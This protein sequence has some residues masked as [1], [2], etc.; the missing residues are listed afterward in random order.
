MRHFRRP[1]RST[2]ELTSFTVN[3][4]INTAVEL[5]EIHRWKRGKEVYNR[6]DTTHDLR[7]ILTQS[8]LIVCNIRQITNDHRDTGQLL[9][10]L[11]RKPDDNSTEKL[12]FGL[13]KKQ[14]LQ[15][16]LRL[17]ALECDGSEDF[18]SLP[19]HHR[20]IEG[21]ILQAT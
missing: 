17:V 9:D 12:E 8:D 21:E 2:V 20:M 19:L 5:T 7:H 6:T 3:E 15:C 14:L 13:F 4:K 16:H 1:N 10:A 11:A 18:P